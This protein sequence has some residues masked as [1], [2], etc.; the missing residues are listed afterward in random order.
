V[1]T[2]F[3]SLSFLIVAFLILLFVLGSISRSKK[4]PGLVEGRLS[5]CTSKPNCVCSEQKEDAN[6]FIDP[7]IIPPNITFDTLP[8]LKNAIREMGG[9]IQAENHNYLAA[10]FSSFLFGFVDDVEIRIDSVQKVIHI[11]SASRVGYGDAGVNKKRSELLKKLF[12]EKV[13]EAN[14]SL[15]ATPKSGAH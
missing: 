1:K 10:T 11:R 2:A 7:I 9:S 8:L 6:H 3:I 15:D 4:A 5:K 14:R 12:N 13:L